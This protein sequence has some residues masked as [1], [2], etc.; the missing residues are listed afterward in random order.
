MRKQVGNSWSVN[1]ACTRLWQLPPRPHLSPLALPLSRYT[2]CMPTG[3]FPPAALAGPHL[4]VFPGLR[5]AKPECRELALPW[6]QLTTN[7]R[8]AGD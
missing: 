2:M 5:V 4:K 6:E 1:K 7:D 8:E 3:Q